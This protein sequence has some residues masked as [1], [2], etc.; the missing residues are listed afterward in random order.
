MKCLSRSHTHTHTH[1]SSSFIHRYFVTLSQLIDW[2]RVY[3]FNTLYTF[4]F[5]RHDLDVFFTLSFLFLSLVRRRKCKIH[6]SPDWNKFN[7]LYTCTCKIEYSDCV[8][9]AKSRFNKL[10]FV[11]FIPFFLF[12]S[13]QK[14]QWVTRLYTTMWFSNELANPKTTKKKKIHHRVWTLMFYF[15]FFF[16]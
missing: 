15:I 9:R 8:N 5:T 6:L 4:C 14:L 13:I 3:P 10:H 7:G 12:S 11:H 2:S 16:I 1:I